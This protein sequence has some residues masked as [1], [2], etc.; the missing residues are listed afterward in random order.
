MRMGDGRALARCEA[1]S[2]I[3]RFHIP[4]TCLYQIQYGCGEVTLFRV[5]CDVV[6]GTGSD[7]CIGYES[8]FSTL[9]G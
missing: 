5:P 8:R 6:T 2:G 9:L 1:E 7:G 3:Q 4:S